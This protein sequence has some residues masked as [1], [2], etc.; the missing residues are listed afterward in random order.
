MGAGPFQ[1]GGQT[2][3]RG[4]LPV[5]NHIPGWGH[6]QT[7]GPPRVTGDREGEGCLVPGRVSSNT[8]GTS[9]LA[10]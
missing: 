3:P 4:S 5:S 1:S 6:I 10:L 2:V 8:V 9:P 7:P